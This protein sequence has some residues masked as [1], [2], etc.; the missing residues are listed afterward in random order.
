[1]TKIT[2]EKGNSIEI[3]IVLVRLTIVDK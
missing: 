2:G 3:K 1:V